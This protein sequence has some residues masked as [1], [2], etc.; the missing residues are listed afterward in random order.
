[1]FLHNLVPLCNRNI[2]NIIGNMLELLL[3]S[4]GEAAN[5]K[6]SAFDVRYESYAGRMLLHIMTRSHDSSIY[7]AIPIHGDRPFHSRTVSCGRLVNEPRKLSV[8]I[9]RCCCCCLS[10]DWSECDRHIECSN[11]KAIENRK[12]GS[13]TRC[14]N[15]NALMHRL[16]PFGIFLHEPKTQLTLLS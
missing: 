14:R 5:E 11:F 12:K 2:Y 15:Q 13:R 10:C 1:M 8:D 16:W 9:F 3:C 4:S 7:Y 6:H